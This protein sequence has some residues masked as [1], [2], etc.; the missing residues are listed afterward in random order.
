MSPLNCSR[1][2]SWKVRSLHIKEQTNLSLSGPYFV[3]LY[4]GLQIFH[5]I[6]YKNLSTCFLFLTLLKV[7]VTEDE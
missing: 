7:S 5:K 4:A 3:I 1:G 2:T 6:V